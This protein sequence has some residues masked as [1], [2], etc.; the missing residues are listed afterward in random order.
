MLC[1]IVQL[2]SFLDI[3]TVFIL[4]LT[5]FLL[6]KIV[7]NRT[8]PQENH[9]FFEKKTTPDSGDEVNDATQIQE[10]CFC[11]NSKE[12]VNTR[13]YQNGAEISEEENFCYL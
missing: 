2:L 5:S 8:L 12:R 11:Q 1:V 9:T 3:L 4:F 10:S 6:G 7:G 13:P